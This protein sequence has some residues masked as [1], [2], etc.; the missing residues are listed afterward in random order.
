ME[1]VTSLA[2]DSIPFLRRPPPAAQAAAP[3]GAQQ[4]TSSANQKDE[5]D[6]KAGSSQRHYQ[7][8]TCRICLETVQPTFDIPT[9]PLP[10]V[11]QPTPKVTYS[12]PDLGR[13]LNPC[14][15][16]G[17]QKYVHEKCL[18]EWRLRDPNSK[19]NFW[20]CPTC[21][22]SYRLERMTWAACISSTTA[23]IVLTLAIFFVAIFVLGY[24]A[25]PIINLYL[26]P[27]DTITSG[28]SRDRMQYDSYLGENTG[29]FEHFAKGLASLG[30]LG[31]AKFLLTMSPWHWFNL[32]GGMGGGRRPA[33]NGRDRL[34][35]ISWFA[36]VVGIIAVLTV[37][38]VLFDY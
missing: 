8:R 37:R 36:V 21:H 19:R 30:L 6:K 10:S 33:A 32:R 24:V 11:L 1:F 16:K 27:Y 4:S 28:L 34:Q 14:L 9:D 2:G 20:Q 22:Y 15:C 31:F 17:T 12:S 35:Q 29:W 25:D 18:S 7:P 23:Q 3:G 13:L 5:K 26:D 38:K